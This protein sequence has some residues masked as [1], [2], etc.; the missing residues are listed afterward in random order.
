MQISCECLLVLR[1]YD[2]NPT[3]YLVQRE[4]KKER[5]SRQAL[6]KYQKQ[7]TVSTILAVKNMILTTSEYPACARTAVAKFPDRCG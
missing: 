4:Q 6:S 3:L 5:T 2:L 7:K 1:I